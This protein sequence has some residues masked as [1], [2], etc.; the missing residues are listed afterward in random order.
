MKRRLEEFH[1]FLLSKD[2]DCDTSSSKKEDKVEKREDVVAN[3]FQKFAQLD[4]S[5]IQKKRPAEDDI[6]MLKRKKETRGEKKIDSRQLFRSLSAAD[7][8]AYLDVVYDDNQADYCNEDRL[9]LV[10]AR[11]AVHCYRKCCNKNPIAF[12]EK[13]GVDTKKGWTFH[14]NKVKGC[15]NCDNKTKEV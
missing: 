11:A 13:Y 2:E 12:K 15:S 4:S 9:F 3:L 6:N 1:G 14:L 10:R 8:I 5:P 7:K